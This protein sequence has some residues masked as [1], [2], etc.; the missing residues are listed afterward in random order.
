[1]CVCVCVFVCAFRFVTESSSSIALRFDAHTLYGILG[2]KPQ[3]KTTGLPTNC[4]H[5]A[6]SRLRLG[7]LALVLVGYALIPN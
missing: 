6:L 4:N 5:L 2:I 3:D 1:V 7:A